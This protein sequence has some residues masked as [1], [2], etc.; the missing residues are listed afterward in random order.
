MIKR[1]TQAFLALTAFS[2]FAE[3]VADFLI[4]S[5]SITID[6]NM[7]DDL[8]HLRALEVEKKA[9]KK[10]SYIVKAPVHKDIGLSGLDD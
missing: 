3:P 2:L 7:I 8:E 9:E 1:T 10:K 5:T 6:A 4:P